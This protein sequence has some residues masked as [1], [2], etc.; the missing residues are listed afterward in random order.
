MKQAPEVKMSLLTYLRLAKHDLIG[1]RT[2]I[3]KEYGD[4]AWYKVKGVKNYYLMHPDHVRHILKDNQ[5]NYLLRHNLLPQVFCP[6]TGKGINFNNDLPQWHRDRSTAMTS[7]EPVL[8]FKDYAAT[9]TQQSGR[10]LD[11]WEKQYKNKQYI[12]VEKEIGELIIDIVASTL[13]TNIEINSEELLAL[14]LDVIEV[15]KDKLYTFP[16]FWPFSK[17]K[18][19]YDEVRKNLK[20][21]SKSVLTQRLNNSVHYDDLIGSFINE[22]KDLPESETVSHICDQIITLF[23]VG[24]FTTSALIHW[25]FVELSLHPEIEEK[26]STELSQVIGTRVPTIDDI[27]S[28]PYLS[29]FIK[30]VLRLHPTLFGV[31]RQAAA[32]DLLGEYEIK[33]G[34]GIIVSVPHVHRHPDF[35]TNPEGFSP[36]RFLHNALG[37][38][39]PFAYIPFGSGKRGCIGAAFSTL[40]ATLITAM[41]IQRYRLYL[42]PNTEIKSHITTVITM[43]P[44]IKTMQLILK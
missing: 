11:R 44:N 43:C 13:F 19:K 36:E 29:A 38:D 32:D 28:L 15:A 40:E 7:F 35:W 8:Y 9:I 5:D 24:Y 27:K 6:F 17:K 1:L 10:M 26:I 12:N 42:P 23:S 16:L 20:S 18:K 14:I 4:I 37:Q 2:Q 3:F 30:E 33:K 41:F 22:Y 39:N 34:G 25:I 31:M 21:L